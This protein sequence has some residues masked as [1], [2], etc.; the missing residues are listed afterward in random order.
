MLRRVQAGRRRWLIFG[1]GAALA[2]FGGGVALASDTI[3]ALPTNLY[4][5]NDGTY[6]T[7]QGQVVPFQVGGGTHNVTST[8]PGPDG[9]ALFRSLTI[10]GGNTPVSGTQYLTAGTYTFFC[11]VHP[12]TMHATLV[13]S[14]NG[15]P[16]ARPNGTLT[17]RT[18]KVSK[19]LKRG[20]QVGI[21]MNSKIDGVNLIARL[22][23]T[24]IARANALALAA[25]QQFEVLKLNKAGKNKLRGKSKATVKLTA[26]I[27]FGLP[28]T[29]KAKL[30]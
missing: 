7:D 16:Q 5:R 22:G 11:T 23:K 26:E 30:K 13:V 12:E 9:K 8:Q 17:V 28:A 29:A 20:I 24:V 6:N 18:K 4:D 19:A 21:N 2:L 14:N 10:S 15:T 1:L 25:G 27:P 3:T